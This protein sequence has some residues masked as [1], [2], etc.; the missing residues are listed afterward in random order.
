MSQHQDTTKPLFSIII[1]LYNKA[2]YINRAIVSVLSQTIRDFELIIVGGKSTDGGED[3]ALSYHDSRIRLIQESGI[4]VSSA[5]NQG[6][7][8][9]KSD[10]IAF[11]DADD[12]W[13]PEFL[14][15]IL[16]LTKSFPNAGLYGTGYEMISLQ[17][18]A[19]RT[20]SFRNCD[21]DCSLSNFY[22]IVNRDFGGWMFILTSAMVIPK[23][24]YLEVGG[25][26]LG[27]HQHEDRC[28]RGKIALKYLVAYS[29]KVSACYYHDI[30]TY[31]GRCNKYLV[32]PFSEY[33]AENPDVLMG[34]NDATD[35]IEFSDMAKLGMA[36][37]NL[38]SGQNR[39]PIRQSVKSVQTPAL[40][41]K[42]NL[43]YL[44]TYVPGF[45]IE[46]IIGLYWYYKYSW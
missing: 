27:Y 4:G 6:V 37:M 21:G 13:K 31:E 5:R 18:G 45:I 38:K 42:R 3:I 36:I 2:Q 24:I 14:E 10:M 16:K 33:L 30:Q 17:T 44:A 29:P 8:E 26:P 39:K 19:R 22:S 11:L 25:F 46:K 34:R 9:A 15:T 1:P 23:S 28:L 40:T 20:Y 7:S 43:I 41:L 35:V 32:D 12:E